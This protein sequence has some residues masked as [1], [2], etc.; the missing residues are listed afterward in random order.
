VNPSVC[1]SGVFM[2]QVKYLLILGS[3]VSRQLH[4]SLRSS[5]LANLLITNKATLIKNAM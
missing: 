2:E 5:R 3:Y 1:C 4:N